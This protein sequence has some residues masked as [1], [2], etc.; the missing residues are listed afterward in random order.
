MV[1]VKIFRYWDVYYVRRII[2]FFYIVVVL[3]SR[4]RKIIFDNVKKGEILKI[5]IFMEIREKRNF[6]LVG[7][8]III[9]FN[10][11]EVFDGIRFYDVLYVENF[12]YGLCCF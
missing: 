9:W 10:F 3:I 2:I 8:G 4:V 5:C 12:F 1:V 7:Y 6:L 11:V